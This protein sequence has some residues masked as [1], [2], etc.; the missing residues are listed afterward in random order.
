MGEHRCAWIASTAYVW[1][2]VPHSLW[3]FA[4]LPISPPTI[5]VVLFVSRST[6]PYF[7]FLLHF[8]QFP[9]LP[10][11]SRTSPPKSLLS[12][13]ALCALQRT[14]FYIFMPFPP[15]YFLSLMYFLISYFPSRGLFFYITIITIFN[16]EV[17]I[18]HLNWR[19]IN[20]KLKFWIQS[21]AQQPLLNRTGKNSCNTVN[22]THRILLAC[23]LPKLFIYLFTLFTQRLYAYGLLILP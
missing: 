6:F 22:Y 18:Q 8:L 3:A 12:M 7:L 1:L 15:M 2:K 10:V 20:P 4:L 21:S 23:L 11:L 9:V 5:V 17:R 19:S 14:S 13:P 16:V